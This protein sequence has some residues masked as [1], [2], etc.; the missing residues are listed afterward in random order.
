MRPNVECRGEMEGGRDSLR[1][2]VAQMET[3]VIL[4]VDMDAFY[5]QVEG[6]NVESFQS[7]RWFQFGSLSSILAR[8]SGVLALIHSYKPHDC[9]L[10][11]CRWSSD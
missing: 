8:A 9:A 7:W 6:C 10:S 2:L 11:G 4:H 5:C 3:R 1:A